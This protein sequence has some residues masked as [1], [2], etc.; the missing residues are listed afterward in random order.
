MSEENDKV[1]TDDEKNAL[2][3]GVESGEIEVQSADGPTYASVSP[4]RIPPRAHIVKNGFPRL[5][6][7]NQQVADRVGRDVEQ[8]LQSEVT[9]VATDL[10]VKSFG[11][12]CEHFNES[13]AAI[14]FE[15]APLQGCGLI[16]IDSPMVRLLVDTF[17]GGDGEAGEV[18]AETSLTI[19]EISVANLFANTVLAAIKDSWAPVQEVTPERVTTEASIDLVDIVIESDPVIAT[20]FDI[21]LSKQECHFQVLLPLEML[22]PLLPIFDGQ[23][24]ERDPVE[25][26]RWSKAIQRRLVDSRLNLTSSIILPEMTVG[27]LVELEPGDVIQFDDPREAAIMANNT[28]LLNG[29][30]GVHRGRNAVETVEWVDPL[31]AEI[32][33]MR[34]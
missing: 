16:A 26:A 30:L 10:I 2:V 5:K 6:V 22:H 24:G 1:L 21:T 29:R 20:G 13:L 3:E 17:Y 9:V 32:L 14:V 27:E 28:R 15:A 18:D 34:S 19:G 4:F 8:L 23:K 25:D 31:Q 12:A 11:R 7:I 33:E